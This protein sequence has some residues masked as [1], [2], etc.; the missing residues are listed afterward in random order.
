MR[1]EGTLIRVSFAGAQGLV[2][3]FVGTIVGRA[4]ELMTSA[5]AEAGQE[6]F[7][8]FGGLYN[9][10]KIDIHE[11][12]FRR[13]ATTALVGWIPP[14]NAR[15]RRNLLVGNAAADPDDSTKR[16]YGGAL[17]WTH[18][19]YIQ[20]LIDHF[21]TTQNGPH[22]NLTGEI[23]AIRNLKTSIYFPQ[24][25][26]ASDMLRE[27]IPVKYGLDYYVRPSF[28]GF[29]IVVFALSDR[30]A[31]VAGATLPNNPNQVTVVKGSHTDLYQT[32]VIET[33]ER[34]YDE[35]KVQGKRIVV[36]GSLRGPEGGEGGT[37]LTKRW[38]QDL[39][40][41]YKTANGNT[42]TH[43]DDIERW[44]EIRKTE[45]FNDVYQHVG[46]PD[47][48]DMDNG[49]WS[50][51]M[52]NDG[53]LTTGPFQTFV[54]ETLSW[55]PLKVGFDYST[56]PPT[57][58]T[59]GSITPDHSHPRAWLYGEVFYQNG[60]ETSLITPRY[61]PVHQ[62]GIHVSHA[63]ED[64]GVV[65]SAA[66]NHRLALNHW[67]KAEFS[68]LTRMNDYE[69]TYDYETA[70]ATIAIESDHRLQ[71][72][73]SLPPNL[74]AGDGSVLV[75]HDDS[76]ELWVLLPGTVVDVD[77][78]GNLLTSGPEL[79]ILR[80]DTDRIALLACGLL[81][82]YINERVR[83]QLD[84]KGHQPW[85]DLVGQI[86][87]VIVGGG[88]RQEVGAPITSVEWTMKPVPTTTIRTGYA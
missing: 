57:D 88:V 9:L 62:A 79:R 52:N 23:T 51:A 7:Q 18:L 24:T 12:L 81:V 19:D 8:A 73:Y 13:D 67:T 3:Q 82:R 37:S 30:T 69:R 49:Q 20:Y 29:D 27:L 11:A 21:L 83:A 50:V 72:G 75:G 35:I 76:A 25:A 77:D 4:A 10:Q 85:G 43:A 32:R 47:D 26:R 84:W 59:V 61:A 66:P 45:K 65:L 58:N 87:S 63:Y 1:L 68:T 55:I 48:W 2:P 36:C 33:N 46:A 14:M 60:V 71:V 86:L 54:R 40:D 41:L 16:V 15:D 53:S 64:W 28:T 39:E 17:I 31:T 42:T 6:V 80:N 74:R 22:W 78:D 44:D 70:I 5:T 34:R 38:S 56:D